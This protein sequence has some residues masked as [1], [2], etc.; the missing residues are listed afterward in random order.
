LKQKTDFP[1]DAKPWLAVGF[2]IFLIILIYS[3]YTNYEK[4]NRKSQVLKSDK[5]TTS[6]VINIIIESEI[7]NVNQTALTV[8]KLLDQADM[9][10]SVRVHILEPVT[11]IKAYD[12]MT[13]LIHKESLMQP[14]YGHWFQEQIMLTK[15]HQSRG[16]KGPSAI[17]H[18]LD[19]TVSI[20]T[21]DWVLYWPSR[22]QPIKSWDAILRDH[23]AILNPLS[24]LCF[25]TAKTTEQHQAKLK[26]D[27]QN[28]VESWFG[29]GPDTKIKAGFFTLDS[30][31]NF[32][33]AAMHREGITKSIG[34]SMNW[35]ILA[36]ALAFNSFTLKCIQYNIFDEELSLSLLSSTTASD[37]FVSG[38]LICSGQ[39]LR[40]VPNRRHQISALLHVLSQ[41]TEE[42]QELFLNK[43][44]MSKTDDDDF[45]I[46]ARA[47]L[48][49]TSNYS[50]QEI[51]IK[52]GSEA[53]FETEK[54]ALKYG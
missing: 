45:I 7:G 42:E 1:I 35:P 44:A 38:K 4:K 30:N 13:P 41:H 50:L 54:E 51:L 43:M 9:P 20:D 8:A 39:A 47:L 49:V 29:G 53:A 18:I 5:I 27:A 32:K 31:L 12:D 14:R 22:L 46:F 16:L 52:Y 28:Y 11:S 2:C 40:R 25:S 3:A 37:I 48:G 23:F 15:V 19:K 36:H 24:F 26:A 21:H 6:G 10:T 34:I 17:H 33:V